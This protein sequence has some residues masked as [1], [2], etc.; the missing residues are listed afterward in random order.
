MESIKNISFELDETDPED[1][2]DVIVELEK[3]FDLK[4]REDAFKHVKTFGDL[5]DV[6]ESYIKYN[7]TE[8]CTK[9][10]A[11]YKIRTSI[12]ETQLI[13]KVSIQLDTQLSDLFPQRDRRRQVKKF[14]KHIGVNLEFLTPPIWLFLFLV[15]GFITSL[16]YIFFNWKIGI[17]GIC[18]FILAFNISNFFGKCLKYDTVRELTENAVINHYNK[19][20]RFN[21]TVNKKEIFSI[22]QEAFSKRLYVDKEILKREAKLNW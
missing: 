16:V 9:Q 19:M 8:D 7:N 14:T 20:R 17:S 22:I 2:S 1:I 3:S 12:S 13:D 21:L 6:F 11:F 18:F 15:I 4:F 10:Q 5:C